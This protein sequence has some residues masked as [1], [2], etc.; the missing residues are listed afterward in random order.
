MRKIIKKEKNRRKE[1]EE[2]NNK[3]EKKTKGNSNIESKKGKGKKNEKK[4]KSVEEEKNKKK[5]YNGKRKNKNGTSSEDSS[6]DSSSKNSSSKN[7]SESDNSDDS[8]ENEYQKMTTLSLNKIKMTSNN[9]QI[10]LKCIFKSLLTIRNK[11]SS[12]YCYFI[13]EHQHKIIVVFQSLIEKDIDALDEFV[14]FTHNY[15]IQNGNKNSVKL[16][17]CP[18]CQLI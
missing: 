2:N 15:T 18:K 13:D 3:Y 4:R 16:S 14:Q 10:N 6:D 8:R 5:K 17:I 9:Y 7:S 11:L 1:E 12:F